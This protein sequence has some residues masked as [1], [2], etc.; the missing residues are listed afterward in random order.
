MTHLILTGESRYQVLRVDLNLGLNYSF[1]E[2]LSISSSYERGSQFRVSF[3][4]TGNFL[5]DS[6]PKPRPKTV[7]RLKT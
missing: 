2:N 6:I 7:Q 3:N 4:L 5:R 1:S